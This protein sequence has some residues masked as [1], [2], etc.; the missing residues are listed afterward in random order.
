MSEGGG[1][2]W[3]EKGVVWLEIV[4]RGTGENYVIYVILTPSQRH[5]SS[6]H[7]D[8][9]G[10][11]VEWFPPSPR[12]RLWHQPGLCPFPPPHGREAPP[13]PFQLPRM[14]HRRAWRLQWYVALTKNKI[15]ASLPLYRFVGLWQIFKYSYIICMFC[16]FVNT[17]CIED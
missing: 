12:H 2:V 17:I 9:R 6:G 8:L 1:K 16:A 11:E 13:P 5:P 15:S 7:P 14:D 4:L 10:L 3:E